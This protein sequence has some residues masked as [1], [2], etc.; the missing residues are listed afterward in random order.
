VARNF[1]YYMVV[2]VAAGLGLVAVSCDDSGSSPC[3]VT[4]PAGTGP[5]VVQPLAVTWTW[6][7]VPTAG[8]RE[9]DTSQTFAFMATATGG[10]PPY[11]F[12]WNFG[13][14]TPEVTG[15]A[16]T[17]QFARP[18]D[19][20][21]IVTVTDSTGNVARSDAA[22]GAVEITIAGIA[23]YCSAD[24]Q[25]GE[26]PLTVE[27]LARVS[28]N[29]G[30][31]IHMWDFG[32]GTTS[33]DRITSHEYALPPARTQ[34]FV[35]TASVTDGLNRSAS[36]S[37]TITVTNSTPLPPAPPPPPP[38]SGADIDV[39]VTVSNPNPV[40]GEVVSF[41]T[42][43]TN[44]GVLD[45]TSVDIWFDNAGMQ[46][47]ACPGA[48]IASSGP[49]VVG[50]LTVGQVATDVTS[51]TAG[52]GPPGWCS[53]TRTATLTASSPSDPTPGNDSDS[54]SFTYP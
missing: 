52:P 29:H 32:D 13:D 24:P 50:A 6:E 39:Q 51:I 37:K 4:P 31:V 14:G 20:T 23:L 1:S 27:F 19:Y 38:P 54:A 35:A 15:N 53:G 46:G 8:L 42:T 44:N 33:S 26:S 10:V 22:S 28:N 21:V 48:P 43:V 5:S 36:C 45:A 17:H 40:L 47:A 7:V 18:G 49:W 11:T 16:V 9:G 34:R 3:A 25:Q 12:A 41:T 2:A 30:P